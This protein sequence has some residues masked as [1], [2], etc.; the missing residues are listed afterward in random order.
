MFHKTNPESFPSDRNVETHVS[1]RFLFQLI[2]ARYSSLLATEMSQT[3][4][5]K[6]RYL[7]KCL[8]NLSLRE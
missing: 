3:F 4:I 8:L 1:F 7:L 5:C 6:I 2:P